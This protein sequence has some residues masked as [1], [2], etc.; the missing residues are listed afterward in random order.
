M[1]NRKYLVPLPPNLSITG[2]SIPN[3][4]IV[5]HKHNN[6][7]NHPM[8]PI[9]P[10]QIQ[11]Y[12]VHL[13]QQTQTN[14]LSN[15]LWYHP[16]CP[17][18][19]SKHHPLRPMPQNPIHQNVRSQSLSLYELELQFESISILLMPKSTTKHKRQWPSEVTLHR[20]RVR[21]H[22]RYLHRIH[23]MKQT[24]FFTLWRLRNGP[25]LRSPNH[26]PMQRN[27]SRNLRWNLIRLQI[28]W[29]QSQWIPIPN[30]RTLSL[31][32]WQWVHRHRHHHILKTVEIEQ[33]WN[34][35]KRW[36][37]N[38]IKRRNRKY[39]MERS[40]GKR[41]TLSTSKMPAKWRR[42]PFWMIQRNG[43]K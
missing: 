18:F 1:L 28:R 27:L 15:P 23:R 24:H 16:L 42:A 41:I 33:K 40:N 35:Q 2:H 8:S 39:S 22:S 5:H 20:L 9:M 10:P 32:L 3:R 11:I 38:W 30:R 25:S 12:R 7:R 26:C 6:T 17:L 14:P 31:T 13:I 21:R 43:R 36:K 19:P 29:L 37:I 34:R 4:L